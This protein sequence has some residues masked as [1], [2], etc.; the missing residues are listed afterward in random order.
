[1]VGYP[2]TIVVGALRGSSATQAFPFAELSNSD[3]SV[4]QSLQI[5]V[6]GLGL[7]QDGNVR[8]GVFKDH[9]ADGS[10][11]TELVLMTDGL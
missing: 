3:G 5:G 1:V 4:P 9:V 8:I 11:I 7:L 10:Q 2:E 6:L